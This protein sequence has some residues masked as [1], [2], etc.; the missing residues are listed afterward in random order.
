MLAWSRTHTKGRERLLMTR[1]VDPGCGPLLARFPRR[2]SS[3]LLEL[4]L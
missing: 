3:P 1:D 2:P 4:R